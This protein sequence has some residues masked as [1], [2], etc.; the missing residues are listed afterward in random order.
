ML[1]VKYEYDEDVYLGIDG[2][3]IVYVNSSVPALVALR[4]VKLDTD[5][6]ARLDRAKVRDLYESPVTNVVST[7]TSRRAGRRYVHLR[8]E[9]ADITRLNEAAP[10]AWATYALQREDAMLVFKQVVGAPARQQVDNVQWR[11]D[12][13]VAFRMH[14]PSRVLWHNAP[15]REVERG[16]II[17][18]EQLLSD[19]LRGLPVVIEVHL[20]SE[21][22]LQRT[23]TLFGA[24]I[25]L[26][27]SAMAFAVWWVMRRA[28]GDSNV[29]ID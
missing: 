13:M 16:N 19:R 11:D 15:S 3:A 29:S 8:I 1:S 4:G 25:V 27:V 7:T 12:E 17:R 21:S 9:V 28:K 23:L 26:A 22:I 6:R 14:L 24:M 2:S 10:F 5:P 20:E 18:W